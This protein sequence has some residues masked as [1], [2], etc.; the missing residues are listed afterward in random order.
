MTHARLPAA[1]L[2][3]VLLRL[4]DAESLTDRAGLTTRHLFRLLAAASSSHL[5]TSGSV[6]VR[7][8]ERDRGPSCVRSRRQAP[9]AQRSGGRGC[10]QRRSSHPLRKATHH[11][12][13]SRPLADT[14]GPDFP[15]S[16]LVAPP[17]VSH[18]HLLRK[19]TTWSD[20]LDPGRL[21][22]EQQGP[23]RPEYRC[24]LP[25]HKFPRQLAGPL[26]C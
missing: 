8:P 16:I 21:P 15:W 26:R 4:R 5:H 1:P 2:R 18:W 19:M 13:M 22:G 11:G 7:P 17:R 12:R 9:A 24:G 20:G 3:R 25:E 6:G 10:P 23:D 14:R